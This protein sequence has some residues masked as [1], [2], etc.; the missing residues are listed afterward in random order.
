[1]KR[2]KLISRILFAITRILAWLYLVTTIYTIICWLLKINIQQTETQNIIKYPFTDTLFLILDNNL[3]Y[4]VFTFLLSFL[5]YTLFFWLLSN[6]FKVFL[7]NKLFTVAN[8]VHLKRFYELNLFVP[9][10]LVILASFFVEIE[11]GVFL[12]IALHLF[13]GIF[14][15]ILSEI[16]KQGVDLQ[17]EQDLY[18]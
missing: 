16:F 8:I 7:Q 18:I 3:T 9:I 12:I 15:F 6:V 5:F 10:L 17:N 11:K 1:M 2:T 13:L 14:V 4:L